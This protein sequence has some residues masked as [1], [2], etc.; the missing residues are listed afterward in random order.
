M[1]NAQLVELTHLLNTLDPQH[2]PLV[3]LLLLHRLDPLN[4]Y[5]IVLLALTLVVVEQ[6][7]QQFVQLAALANIQV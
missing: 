4:V 1:Q 7:V 5:Q 6:E 3:A 2:A